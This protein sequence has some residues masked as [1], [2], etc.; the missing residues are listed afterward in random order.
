MYEECA[1]NYRLM[2]FRGVSADNYVFPKVLK[3]CAQLSW[4][5]GGRWVHGSVVV[6]GCHWNLQ[7]CNALIDMYA[8]CGE[9]SSGK[10]VFEEME[11][12]DLLSWNSLISGY[13]SNGLL[14]LAVQL[15]GGLRL[16]GIEPDIITLNMVLDAYSR[17]CL[18][19][20][21]LKIFEHI[22]NPNIISWTTLMSGYSK[23]GEYETCL[24]IFND[25]VNEGTVFPDVDSLSLVLASCRHLCAL[26]YGKAIH[27]YGIKTGDG[28]RFYRSAGPALLTMYAK[29][30]SIQ[31][32]K[33]VFAVMDKSDVVAWNAVILA[34]AELEL[35]DLALESF[36]EMQ[37]IGI[38]N[39]QTTISTVLPLCDL[40]HGKQI[41]AYITRRIADMVVTVWN[42][43]IHMY[44]SC[45]KIR[46][47]YSVF[48]TLKTRD[49]V[50]WNTMIRGFG[51]HG[52]GQAALKLVQ[53]MNQL[54]INPDSITLTSVL[55]ACHHSGLVEEGL[56]LF[57]SMTREYGFI[58]RMEH[59]SCVV[60][61][62][63]R[64]GRLEDATAFIHQMPLQPDKSV[65][66]ALLAACLD[67]Q[68][69]DVG[70]L[71][72]E[73]LVHLEPQCAG[74][75]VTLSNLYTE[76]SNWDEAVR[77]RKQMEVRGLVKMSGQSWIT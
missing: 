63:A 7:V 2:K 16:D 33:T 25:M 5:D 75:Y 9:V 15:L 20:E 21:A 76:S 8:K 66:G 77:V 32:A 12:R 30:D 14:E 19:D 64:A 39:D 55:S 60:N 13:V 46:A 27:G 52:L 54:G 28:G 72:A 69:V 47:A 4:L 73:Q 35:R 18:C 56:K 3:A 74:H 51:M 67:Q 41:H 11:M 26:K 62:L 36:S 59:Y 58:P 40:K 6:S 24:R 45:G 49:L 29:C 37:K 22:G 10:L 42:A 70:K 17:M 50:T 65:W 43:V 31:Y 53:D 57:D 23:A 34:F 1:E 61:M 48:S 71:A 38:Q 68:N 44:C